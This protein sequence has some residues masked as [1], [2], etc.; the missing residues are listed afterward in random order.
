MPA[1]ADILYRLNI[2]WFLFGQNC[3]NSFFFRSKE[4]SPLDTIPHEL[5]DLHDDIRNH[6]LSSLRS[7]MSSDCQLLT[8][9]LF[10]L[11]GPEFYT[12]VRTYEGQFGNIAHSS[13]PTTIAQVLSWRTAYRGRRVHGRSYIPGVP[14]AAQVANELSPDGQSLLDNA[15]SNIVGFFGDGGSC[16]SAWFVCFSR[17]NGA[18]RSPGPPPT[19]VYSPLAGI[20]VNRY[21]ADTVLFTQRHRLAGRG[22]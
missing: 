4:T 16:R 22:I 18:T 19:I 7:V 14:Q 17:K 5:S 15:G 21:V 8:S 3:I 6:L 9:I 11:N 1:G 13:L 10:N 2:T 12:D 20:P